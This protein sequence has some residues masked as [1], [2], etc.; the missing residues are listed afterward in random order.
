M[1]RPAAWDEYER[2]VMEG[3]GEEAEAPGDDYEMSAAFQEWLVERMRDEV[4]GEVSK[5]MGDVQPKMRDKA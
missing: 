2:L 3:R 1:E 5:A 4:M